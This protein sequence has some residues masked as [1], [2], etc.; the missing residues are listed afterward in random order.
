MALFNATPLNGFFHNF[1]VYIVGTR[2]EG[3]G[4]WVVYSITCSYEGGNQAASP[5]GLRHTGVGASV[6]CFPRSENS[7]EGA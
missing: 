7:A 5:W 6:T 2:G 3:M 1:C 4:M